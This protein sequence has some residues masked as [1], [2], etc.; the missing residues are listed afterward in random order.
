MIYFDNAATTFPKPAAVRKAVG[1]SFIYYGAN[2]GRSGHSLAMD[3]ARK[4]FECREKASEFFGLSAPE[5][6]VFTKNCTEALNIVLMSIGKE[7]GHFIISDLEHNSVLRPLYDM[8]NRGIIDFSVAKTFEGEPEKTIESYNK[9]IRSDT[10]M[11]VAAGASNV[12]GIKLPVE[13][14]AEL[15]HEHGALFTLD[16]AQTAGSEN[17]DMEKN[18]IDFVCAPGHKGLLGPM[19]TGMLASARPEYLK[20]IIFGGTGSYSLLPNQPEGLPEM[21]ESGTLNVPGICGLSAGIDWVS[22]K[23]PDK[24]SKGR[25]SLFCSCTSENGY[26]KKR[27]LSAEHRSNEHF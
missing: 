16:A 18:G 11:L 13:M 26:G 1:E 10:K 2:P 24:I 3:T 22:K 27:Y 6:L 20:P 21:L 12:F 23:G 19:G 17:I 5:N 9:L 8:K 25:F 4:V 7:G 15:A 14:L